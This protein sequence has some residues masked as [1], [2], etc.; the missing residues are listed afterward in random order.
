MTRAFVDCHACACLIHVEDSTCPFCSAAQRRAG[1]PLWLA[2]SLVCGLG[3]VDI[4]CDEHRAD[5]PPLLR[6]QFAMSTSGTSGTTGTGTGTTINDTT[7][8]P[9][10]TTYAGPDE[11]DTFGGTTVS[12][13]GETSTGGTTTTTTADGTTYAGP[14]ETD[15]I[16]TTGPL[17]GTTADA[18][19]DGP[20]ETAGDSTSG[21]TSTTGST[22]S[23]EP[24]SGEKDGCGCRSERRSASGL[25]GLLGLLVLRRR[26]SRRAS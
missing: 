12:S 21:T 13:P 23:G 16:P 1:A 8:S 11:T 18:S 20:S 24:M 26:R 5:A 3:L 14:D 19:S 7:I 4:G 10:G 6:E 17:P 25:L 22:D 9:D 15:T 2:V